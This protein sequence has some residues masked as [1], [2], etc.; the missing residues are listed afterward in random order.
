M[1][2]NSQRSLA[3]FAPSLLSC[4]S[5]SFSSLSL[6]VHAIS[7]PPFP[8][9]PFLS[10]SCQRHHSPSRALRVQRAPS[11]LPSESRTNVRLSVYH[12]PGKEREIE[13]EKGR[14]CKEQ[15]ERE[16]RRGRSKKEGIYKIMHFFFPM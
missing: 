4:F 14:S 6:C 13:R 7:L 5:V 15:R 8:L 16:D 12:S 1:G 9:S 11:P 2:S 10:R 3:L